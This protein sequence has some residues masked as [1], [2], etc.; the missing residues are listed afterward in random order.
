MTQFRT[1]PPF[2][3]DQRAVAE[4]VR[5]IMDGKTNNTGTVTLATGG[6]TTTTINNERI[7]YTS[8]ILLMPTSLDAA[9]YVTNLYVS[10]KVQGSA[11]LTHTANSTGGRSYDYI[12]A[13]IDESRVIGYWVLQPDGNKLH[14]WAGWSLENRHDNLENGL[15]Y[16]KEI[17][18]QGNAKYIT[19]SSHR[20]GWIKRAKSLGFSPR[21]W[22]SEV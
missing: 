15:K 22:I 16:I 3:G 11:T 9:A 8:V 6:A 7:G 2:G 5:G 1:L 20:K 14:V 13:L 4:V 12:I 10:A 19:F 21:L 18:R 17:A